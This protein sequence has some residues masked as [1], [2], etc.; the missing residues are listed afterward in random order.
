[1]AKKEEKAKQVLERTYNIPLRREWLKA[2]NYRRAKKAISAVRQF[3][4]RHMKGAPVRLGPEL[5]RRIWKRGIKSPPHHIKVI[6]V[7]YDDGSVKAELAGFAIE[8]QKEEKKEH[9][10]EKKESTK[11]SSEEKKTEANGEKKGEQALDNSTAQKTELKKATEGTKEAKK[12]MRRNKPA[13][14]AK[15]DA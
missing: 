11:A 5:N 7:K 9:K 3:L 12:P 15:P 14:A 8:A 4:E 1:L 13:E 10:E 2:P 6:T